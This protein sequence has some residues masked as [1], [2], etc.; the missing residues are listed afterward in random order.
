MHIPRD[1]KLSLPARM[2]TLAA[3]IA[4]SWGALYLGYRLIQWVWHG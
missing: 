1:D 3:L 2:R 4:L